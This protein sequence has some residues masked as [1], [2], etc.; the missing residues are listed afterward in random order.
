MVR[1]DQ[2]GNGLSDWAAEDLSF[3][4]LVDDLEAVAAAAGLQRYALLGISQGCAI[5]IAHAV[6]HPERVTAL[7]LYGGYVHGWAKRGTRQD[8]EAREAMVTLTRHGWG[9]PDP[10]YR[11]LFTSLFCPGATLEQMQAFNEMQRE[12]ASPE[13]A[14]RLFRSFGDIDVTA[15]LP[16]V[17]VPTLVLHARDDAVVPFDQGRRMAIGIPGAR[18][19]PLDGR[20]H[21]LLEHEPAW[22]TFLA[23]VRDF[24][25]RVEVQDRH[26]MGAA[27][28]PA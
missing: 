15:L 9:R 8:V 2:R 18:F 23:E 14:V 6:R 4:A 1:Y 25:G 20:N 10:A 24:L 28:P 5:A 12:S 17:R 27:P 13:N 21:I 19:V 3:D 7:V 16:Q 22:A 26:G 11:Q